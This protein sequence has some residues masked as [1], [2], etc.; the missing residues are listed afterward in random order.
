VNLHDILVAVADALGSVERLTAYPYALTVVPAGQNDVAAVQLG[1]DGLDY[2][3]ALN[4]GLAWVPVVIE[5]NVQASSDEDAYYRMAELLSGGT[6]AD[7]SVIDALEDAYRADRDSTP[8]GPLAGIAV[9]SATRPRF[10]QPAEG[11]PRLLVAEVR[12]DVPTSRT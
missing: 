7:R 10:E 12:L 11:G 8:P 3:E 5:L 2:L 6:G 1:D 9:Q 4:G